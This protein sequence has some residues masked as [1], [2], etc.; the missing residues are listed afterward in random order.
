MENALL[1]K[2]YLKP[3]SKVLI[4]NLPE[5]GL[6]LLGDT[7]SITLINNPT[8]PFNALL[9]FV[10]N[11][12]ELKEALNTWASKITFEV[13]VWI[14]YPKK[15][16]G[17]PTDLKMAKWEELDQYQLSPCG[18]ASI[19]DTWTGLRIKP[20]LDVKSSGVGNTQI[21]AN[22]FSEFIDVDNKKVYPPADLSTMFLQHPN[23][24]VFF[25]ELAYSHQKEY[26]LW[27][28]TAKQEATRVNRLQKTIEMLSIE[29]KSPTTR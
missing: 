4:G 12:T 17:V 2:L 9:L 27:I 26:V 7:S 8:E 13:I 23:A 1:K 24:A 22:E 6:S 20:I 29:K 11:S 25:K 18:S 16:S 14:A 3:G 5:Q 10:K 15:S 21:K 28:L 19:D